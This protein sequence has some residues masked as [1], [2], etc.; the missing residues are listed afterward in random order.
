MKV[1]KRDLRHG[2]VA[3]QTENLDD[4]WYLSQVL[5]E[6]DVVK[7]RTTRLVKSKD[8]KLRADKGQKQAMTLAIRVEKV[9]FDKN[10]NRLRVLGRIEA[11]PE[12]LIPLGSH[13]TFEL[14]ERDN[15]TIMKARWPQSDLDYLND[16]EAAAKRAKIM[17]CI[18]GDGEATLAV[19]RESGISYAGTRENIGGKYV[20]GREERKTQF[21]A[22]LSKLLRAQLE[23]ERV[24]RIVVGGSGFEKRNFYDYLKDKDAELAKNVVVVDTGSEGKNG[25][26]EVLKG[27]AAD[28]I[29]SETRIAR[30]A[31]FVEKLLEGIAKGNLAV[32]GLEESS[33][34]VDYGAVEVLLI[35][36]K[37]FRDK[38]GDLERLIEK[39]K[40]V[41]GGFHI[42]NSEYEPGE[43][44]DGLG[45]I[46]ALLRYKI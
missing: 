5:N 3:V 12:D 33:R 29:A 30:E 19:V 36:D 7:A 8:D 27:G 41:K 46:A 13:H 1:L 15:V 26:N 20:T 6:G 35:S 2:I 42:L 10:A 17:I 16:A 39:T 14:G 23:K 24:D 38:R 4:L 28:K 25:V 40:S 45:G 43:K 22:E 44:L 31:R 32:Y 34:A 18:V 37:Y 11:G 21:Y 9:E